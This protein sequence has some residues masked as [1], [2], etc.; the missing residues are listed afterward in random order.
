MITKN[1]LI[2]TGL[3]FDN[4]HTHSA[5]VAS[6]FYSKTKNFFQELFDV[7]KVSDINQLVKSKKSPNVCLFSDPHEEHS[8]YC[9]N[10]CCSAVVPILNYEAKEAGYTPIFSSIKDFFL[11][12]EGKELEITDYWKKILDEK[13]EI[14][15]ISTSFI[16]S[17]P[18]LCRMVELLKKEGK[19]IILGG[20]FMRKLPHKALEHLGVDYYLI[21]E[22]EGRFSRLLAAIGKNESKRLD[23]IPG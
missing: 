8:F 17:Y 21:S 10:S 15:A 12:N 4:L 13:V 6:H 5:S 23:D 19:K 20:V 2:I 9:R 18:L 1:I 11:I 16:I 3:S 14:V 7:N 22:A